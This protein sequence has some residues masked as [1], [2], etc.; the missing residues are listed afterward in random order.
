MNDKSDQ[1]FVDANELLIFTKSVL[2]NQG[3]CESHADIFADNLVDANLRGKDSHGI[4]RLP[5]YIERIEA[6]GMETEPQITTDR[7][8][9]A[10]ALVDADN[11]PGQV[12]SLEAIEVGMDIAESFG[13]GVVGVINSNHFGTASYYTNHATKSGFVGI[14]VS[15]GGP[16]VTPFAGTKKRLSTNP[17]S[18]GIPNNS[19]PVNVDISTSATALGTIL[20]ADAEDEE[21][22]SEWAIDET[23]N[24]TTDP[25]EFHALRPMAG[26]KGYALAFVI[27]VLCGVLLS[28]Y[29]STSVSGLYDDISSP[30]ELAHLFI[31]IDIEAFV[32]RDDFNQRITELIARMKE[33]PVRDS[34]EADDIYIPGERAHQNKIK[35]LNEG[36]PIGQEV[37]KELSKISKRYDVLLPSTAE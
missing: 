17:I 15:H 22:P 3:F 36:I 1:K 5:D 30:Q 35:R 19:Y 8:T 24:P 10:T 33:T 6:G 23:G 34:A 7:Q 25:S 31:V 14:G 27:D 28:G 29:T 26:H 2:E 4:I 9:K 12:S 20:L 37:W 32:S 21:I 11:G 13:A 16:I 18:I